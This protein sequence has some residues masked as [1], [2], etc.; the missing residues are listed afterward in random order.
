M[1]ITTV[2]IAQGFFTV[3]CASLLIHLVAQEANDG[4]LGPTSAG[5]LNL[6]LEISNRPNPTLTLINRG[7]GASQIPAFLGETLSRAL[8]EKRNVEFPVCLDG[9]G[10]E[11]VTV[12]VEPTASDEMTLT[13]ANGERVSYEVSIRGNRGAGNTQAKDKKVQYRQPANGLCDEDSALKVE[14][15]LPDELPAA[16]VAQLRGRFR[17]MITAE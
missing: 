1:K 9:T 15:T 17:L 5:R 16:S 3:Y 6:S 11:E 8:G 10:G 7:G 2:R 4:A 12:S 13:G 14:V